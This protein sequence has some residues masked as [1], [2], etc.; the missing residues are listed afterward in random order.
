MAQSTT[1]P[2]EDLSA[3][4]D[5]PVLTPADI[6]IVGSAKELV[7]NADR[8]VLTPETFSKFQQCIYG[9]LDISPNPASTAA[10]V[11][12]KLP[13]IGLAQLFNN[14]YQACSFVK[15]SGAGRPAKGSGNNG[16]T[17]PADIRGS[18]D[19]AR[20]KQVGRSTYFSDSVKSIG[21]CRITGDTTAPIHSC[22]IIAFSSQGQGEK[23]QLY[24]DLIKALFGQSAWE[25]LL[26]NVMNGSKDRNR[27]I[28]R[29]DNGI[30]LSP[31][32]H[33]AW[34]SMRFTLTPDWSSYNSQTKE[35]EAIFRWIGAPAE[36]VTYNWGEPIYIDPESGSRSWRVV[37]NGDR[38]PFHRIPP[39]PNPDGSS[40]E[41]P[42]IPSAHLLYVRETLVRVAHMVGA[43]GEYDNYTYDND[44]DSEFDELAHITGTESVQGDDVPRTPPNGSLKVT[45]TKPDLSALHPDTMRFIDTW[46]SSHRPSSPP[47]ELSDTAQALDLATTWFDSHS[48]IPTAIRSKSRNSNRKE[49]SYRST[50]HWE[51]TQA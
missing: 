4:Y 15:S 37:R 26:T 22:H 10:W 29:L 24:Q 42:P 1:F 39:P 40:R 35:F 16:G 6:E 21:F 30:P 17:T 19:P 2:E 8:G 23:I 13:Q 46:F 36:G 50:W 14:I 12:D 32:A 45:H 28:N 7:N 38:I 47:L 31:S 34:D 5:P 25:A 27:N 48:S 11:I 18:A 41:P 20:V 9:I 33:S 44:S 51:G 43:S 3:V 49:Y